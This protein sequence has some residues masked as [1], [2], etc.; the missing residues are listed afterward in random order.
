MEI[1]HGLVLNRQLGI[2]SIVPGRLSVRLALNK[3]LLLLAVQIKS[4]IFFVT[5]PREYLILLLNAGLTIGT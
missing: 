1:A 4:S 3:D 5:Q 2:W